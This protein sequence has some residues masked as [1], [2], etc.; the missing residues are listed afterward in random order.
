MYF[1]TKICLLSYFCPTYLQYYIFVIFEYIIYHRD[2]GYIF[3]TVGLHD[4]LNGVVYLRFTNVFDHFH[5]LVWQRPCLVSTHLC[6]N[7]SKRSPANSH[8]DSA[9]CN[10]HC[11]P[12]T[13][14]W[15]LPYSLNVNWHEWIWLN[16][17]WYACMSEIYDHIRQITVQNRGTLYFFSAM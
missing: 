3:T 15:L 12:V 6:S 9:L 1:P 13:G 4:L 10:V 17:N 7:A 11:V 2:I 14:F 5:A 8:W 16:Q